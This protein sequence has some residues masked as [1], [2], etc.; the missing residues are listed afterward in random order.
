M[1]SSVLKSVEDVTDPV[2]Q[3]NIDWDN[4]I[5]TFGTKG[6]FDDADIDDIPPVNID[7]L[8]ENKIADQSVDPLCVTTPP[9]PLWLSLVLTNLL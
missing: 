3:A 8:T 7:W 2:V 9:P 1:T 5:W 6:T 4:L